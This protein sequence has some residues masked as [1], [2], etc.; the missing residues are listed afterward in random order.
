VAK[1]FDLL[2]NLNA[3]EVVLLSYELRMISSS[4]AGITASKWNINLNYE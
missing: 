1:S 4:K 2:V 3:T